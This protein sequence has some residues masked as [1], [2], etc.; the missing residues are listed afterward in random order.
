MFL[1]AKMWNQPSYPSMEKCTW[2]VDIYTQWSIIH[3]Q[4]RT[5]TCLCRKMDETKDIIL[6]KISQTY[7]YWGRQLSLV[8]PKMQNLENHWKDDMKVKRMLV[9]RKRGS[10]NRWSNGK[11]GSRK[12]RN[13]I[14]CRYENDTEVERASSAGLSPSFIKPP[15]PLWVSHSNLLT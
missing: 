2:K 12:W 13:C 4:E 14:A 6:G 9:D 11:K 10:G 5:K 7:K 1:M 3:P 15:M 8:F